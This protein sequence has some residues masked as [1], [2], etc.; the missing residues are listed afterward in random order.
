MAKETSWT[1]V[2][3]ECR[4][5]TDSFIHFGSGAEGAKKESENE[6]ELFTRY[7]NEWKGTGKGKEQSY[8]AIPR[9]YFKV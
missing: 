4:K 3:V 7:F 6:T 9:F 5:I 2:C 8:Q 1:R